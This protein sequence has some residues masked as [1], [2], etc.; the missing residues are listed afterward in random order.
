MRR[1]CYEPAVPWTI[2]SPSALLVPGGRTGRFRPGGDQLLVG[3]DG[4]GQVSLEDYAVAMLDEL[5]TPRHTHGRF[6]VRY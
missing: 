6:T 3:P 5:E 4:V 1:C 2:L